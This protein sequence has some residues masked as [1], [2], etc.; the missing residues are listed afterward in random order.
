MT[1]SQLEVNDCLQFVYCTLGWCIA[2]IITP[3][4]DAIYVQGVCLPTS[5]VNHT[6]FIYITSHGTFI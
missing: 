6:R 5:Y 3:E 1:K 2:P 4:Y